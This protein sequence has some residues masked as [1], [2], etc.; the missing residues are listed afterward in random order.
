MTWSRHEHKKYSKYK[1][2]FTMAMPICIKQNLSN[3]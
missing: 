1:K 3:I 2:C